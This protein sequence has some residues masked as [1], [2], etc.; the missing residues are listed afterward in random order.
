MKTARSDSLKTRLN[1]LEAASEIFAE[2]GFWNATHEEISSRANANVASINYHFGSKENFY[3]EAWKYS[4]EK[5]IRKHP[6][7]GNTLP[8]D[9]VEERIRGR[10]LSILKRVI[11]PDAHDINIM[12]K[13]LSNPTGLLTDVF[14]KTVEPIN[15]SFKE[16]IKEFLGEGTGDDQVEFCF[17]SIMSQCFTPMIYHR[18]KNGDIP[19]P[20]TNL[21]LLEL[22]AER[23]ADYITG[24]IF[25]GINS[26]RQ[27]SK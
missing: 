21:A 19:M 22:G 14:L 13:E 3:I 10:I 8:G 7:E 1:L 20:N 15:S 27:D 23:L 26:F 4:F 5:S 11:D 25:Y 16:T 18:M 2:K 17:I 12:H 9:P 24:F 6:P